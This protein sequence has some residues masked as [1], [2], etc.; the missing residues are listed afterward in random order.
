MKKAIPILCALVLASLFSGCVSRTTSTG[1]E[2]HGDDET[3]YGSKQN[4]KV[5]EKKL[6]WF[7]QED[8]RKPK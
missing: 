3:S 5:I 4:S 7:W 1:P 8:F 6:I 2:K